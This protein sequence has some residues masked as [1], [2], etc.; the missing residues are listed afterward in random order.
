MADLNAFATAFTTEYYEKFTKNRAALKD[1]HA[2]NAYFTFEGAEHH[3]RQAIGEKLESLQFGD[4][5]YKVSTVDAQL[6]NAQ[7]NTVI[8]SVTGMFLLGGE[9]NPLNFNQVFQLAPV[10]GADGSTS[11]CVFNSIFRLNL[12]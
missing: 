9:S 5:Q 7:L 6:S 11:F 10:V 8:V 3:G 12:G 4:M 2:E 1:I